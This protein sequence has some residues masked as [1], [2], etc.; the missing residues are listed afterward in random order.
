MWAFRPV[1]KFVM[2]LS[3]SIRALSFCSAFGVLYGN[4]WGNR[5]VARH[6]SGR[7]F[8]PIVSQAVQL[9]RSPSVAEITPKQ[10]QQR[11]KKQEWRRKQRRLR[12][13]TEQ[14]MQEKKNIV[15][16]D[17]GFVQSEAEIEVEDEQ[18]DEITLV[19]KFEE[20]FALR[21]RDTTNCIEPSA[22]A[23]SESNEGEL[24]VNSNRFREDSHSVHEGSLDEVEFESVAL[25]DWLVDNERRSNDDEDTSGNFIEEIVQNSF[26][27]NDGV[28]LN[29][30]GTDDVGSS[31]NFDTEENGGCNLGVNDNRS[32]GV[33]CKESNLDVATPMETLTTELLCNDNFNI[34]GE[35]PS[36]VNVRYES[37]EE[38]SPVRSCSRSQLHFIQNS[39]NKHTSI[40]VTDESSRSH[41]TAFSTCSGHETRDRHKTDAGIAFEDASCYEGSLNAFE[42]RESSVN[43]EISGWEEDTVDQFT[44][45]RRKGES[46]LTSLDKQMGDGLPTYGVHEELH[47][48]ATS[49]SRRLP[50][51]ERKHLERLV[52]EYVSHLTFVLRAGK[53]LES[54]GRDI[55]CW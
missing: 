24:A 32:L 8:L 15:R 29:N 7:V 6:S 27:W 45:N 26:V 13:V 14:E 23:I 21:V 19:G 25:N 35:D 10:L 39:P 1:S 2:E 20:E 11:R 54:M 42:R 51:S 40:K 52:E 3:S 4:P 30:G 55:C 46:L 50:A 22:T 18:V 12:R 33:Q 9:K 53:S 16:N 36:V 49:E 38:N 37:V 48:D 47:E 44:M 34:T 31:S 43:L 5:I 41:S 28:R 17:R